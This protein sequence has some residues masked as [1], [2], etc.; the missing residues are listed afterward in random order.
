[1]VVSAE[2]GE[3][4]Q[5]GG[6]AEDPVQNVV[7]VA[8]CG[9]WV[10]P[11]KLQPPSRAINAMVWPGEASRRVLPNAS[12]TPCRLMMV[13]QI[14]PRRRSAAADQSE[15]GAVAVSANPAL[16][17]RSSIDGDDHGGGMP[18]TSG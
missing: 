13:G 3:I 18:P 7:S 15:L 12:G 2:Q 4:V 11:G 14:R 1:M 16:A 17:N 5:V 8:P 6:A 9:G 10:Q